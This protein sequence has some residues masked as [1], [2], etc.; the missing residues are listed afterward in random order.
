MMNVAFEVY[1]YF[2]VYN[3]LLVYPAAGILA[4]RLGHRSVLLLQQGSVLKLPYPGGKKISLE[5]KRS[6]KRKGAR[7]IFLS[8][9]T[10]W[11][12]A[13]SSFA[14]CETQGTTASGSRGLQIEE[15]L[16]FEQDAPSRCG[17]DLPEPPSHEDRLGPAKRRG[18]IGLPG[19]SEPQVARHY[20]R[21]SQK[22][23][24][25]PARRDRGGEEAGAAVAGGGGRVGAGGRRCRRPVFTTKAAK[26]ARRTRRHF[27]G[28]DAASLGAPA[29]CRP[30]NLRRRASRR[31]KPRDRGP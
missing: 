22:N 18:T 8:A 2:N 25:A 19:L 10:E 9:M 21:L 14:A 27:S 1:T 31:L 15:K 12:Q 28:S 17:V 29:S 20:T 6:Q 7:V 3:F 24:A 30:G 13:L 5:E 26:V 4:L 23:Y 16:L 11:S